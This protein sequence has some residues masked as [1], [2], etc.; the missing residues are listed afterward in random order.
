MVESGRS[1]I[2]SGFLAIFL[3]LVG[4]LLMATKHLVI[5]YFKGGYSGFDQALDSAILEGAL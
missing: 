4:A 2:V 3:G 1:K 5:R